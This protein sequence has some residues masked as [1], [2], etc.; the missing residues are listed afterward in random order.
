MLSPPFKPFQK[1]KRDLEPVY[2]LSLIFD[3]FFWRKI[4][5]LLYSINWPNFIDWLSLLCEILGNMCIAIVFKPGCDVINFKVNLTFLIKPFWYMA[6]KSM[7]KLKYLENGKSFWD[8]IK[9]FFHHFLRAFNQANNTI[10]FWNVG[11]R[12]KLY[13]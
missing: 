11:V 1:I 8:E 3:M 13:L 2:L 5:F 9:N 6:K 10:F 12:L 4:L 7:Q